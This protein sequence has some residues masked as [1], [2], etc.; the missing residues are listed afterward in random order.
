MVVGIADTGFIV[1]LNSR[2][3]AERKWARME[4]ERVGAPFYTCEGA[5]IEAAHF[6]APRIIARLLHVGDF[7]IAFKLSEQID[8]VASLLEKYKD[9]EMDLTDACV[10]RMSELFPDCKVYTVD[11]DF[12]VYRRFGTNAIPANYPPLE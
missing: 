9:Q 1:A 12:D 10:V 11:H 5:L 3:A 8:P 4:F 7:Q 6:I 2:I